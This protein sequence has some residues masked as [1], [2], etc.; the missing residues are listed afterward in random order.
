M[1]WNKEQRNMFIRF[2][3]LL[4]YYDEQIQFLHTLSI[5]STHC[6]NLLKRNHKMCSYV[7][8]W[9]KNWKISKIICPNMYTKTDPHNITSV[10]RRLMLLQYGIK[11]A[12]LFYPVDPCY[13]SMLER[14]YI[15]AF[16]LGCRL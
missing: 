5:T 9:N 3:S 11:P 13:G 8:F 16:N 15:C 12:A 6:V 14:Y 10:F 2:C 4:L 7:K 1:V